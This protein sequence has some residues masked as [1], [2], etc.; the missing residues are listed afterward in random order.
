MTNETYIRLTAA[1]TPASTERLLQIVDEK[2]R[3]GIKRLH[4]L[5]ST[6]GG[7]VPHGITL[8][9]FLKGIPMEIYTHNFGT[10]DSIGV[11]VFCAGVKRYSVSDARFFLHPVGADI[12]SPTRIDEH[13]LLERSQSLKIDQNNIAR[14][15]A[16]TT[17]RDLQS[18]VQDIAKRHTLNPEEALQYGLVSEIKDNVLPANADFIAI[19]E[20]EGN[21][22]QTF[23]G[24]MIQIAAPAPAKSH[25]PQASTS[26]I[27]ADAGVL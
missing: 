24:P 15:I 3:S 4:L 25:P 16:K 27:Y 7:A 19:H 21:A 13:W 2:Y 26:N 22:P 6:P 5:L 18:I 23:P 11:I 1:I 17:E 9:N 10:V 8:Y 14:I 12:T 20:S